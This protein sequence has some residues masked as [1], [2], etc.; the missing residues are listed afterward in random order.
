MEKKSNNS[1]I[2][3]V[4]LTTK[5]LAPK[6][7]PRNHRYDYVFFGNKNLFPQDMI[8]LADNSSIHAALLAVK[9]KFIKGSGVT[10]E[11]E[12]KSDIKRAER[13][14][15]R[16]GVNKHF[17]EKIAKDLA[18][19]GGFYYQVL[20]ERGG[21]PAKVKHIDFSMVRSGKM[22]E[23]GKVEEFWIS[24]DWE[25]ATGRRAFKNDNKIYEPRPIAVW[26]SNDRALRRERGELIIGKTYK[27]GKLF[28][29]EPDYLA[30]VNYIEISAQIA[31]LH[32]NNIDNGMVGSMHIHLFE[33]LS[34]PEKRRKV[35]KGIN[36]KFKGSENAGKIVV[37]WS[38]DPTIAAQVNALP[39]SASHE[40]FAFLS[41]KVNQ[42]I[43]AAHS[44]PFALANIKTASGLQSESE[45]NRISLESFQNTVINPM[46]DVITDSLEV[47]LSRIG[48]EVDIK[49]K[50]LKP[51]DLLAS[52]QLLTQ[53][54]EVNEI[55]E[56]ILGLEPLDNIKEEE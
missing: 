31:E 27:P 43:S 26:E 11:S 39:V 6:I 45:L 17:I 35:E 40:M 9:S 48:L 46:Q 24:S 25:Y 52:E 30:A 44:V 47:V 36:D 7:N 18:Y 33:D 51:V 34:D 1:N 28:Y 50:P 22:N 4:N 5:D 56:K 38:T 55:R 8:K 21:R 13:E 12:R 37:T 53:V 15:E 41:E 3:F 20:S 10:I 23:E 29:A 49:L 32:K 14:L 42:E 19:F 2:F 16:I 54:M